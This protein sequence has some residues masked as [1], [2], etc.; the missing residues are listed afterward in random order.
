MQTRVS[1]SRV[2]CFLLNEELDLAAETRLPADEQNSVEI[3]NGS[4][5]WND[6]P[7][8]LPMLRNINVSV[9]SGSLVAIVGPV[10][11][12]KSSL[13]A[14]ML[15]LMHRLSGTVAVK[16]NV[17]YVTQQ[18]WIQNLTLRKNILFGKPFDEARYDRVLQACALKEDLAMLPAG[19]Q[20]E[21]GEKGWPVLFFLRFINPLFFVFVQK[22]FPKLFLCGTD[23]GL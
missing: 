5:S 22:Y 12:G 21:I 19:D 14:A 1:V 18:A 20:T 6:G 16:E 8:A 7:L 10:G 13:V 3:A 9:P 4:F 11:A 17:A 23:S 15:G 2:K